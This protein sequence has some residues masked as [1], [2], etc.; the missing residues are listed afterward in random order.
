MTGDL[1]SALIFL[2][3]VGIASYL[4]TLVGFSYGVL[5]VSAATLLGVAPIKY[6]AAFVSFTSLFN[7]IIAL[8]D[9]WQKID[10]PL[11]ALMVAGLVPGVLCGV[12]L[13][14]FLSRYYVEILRLILGLTVL[15][16]AALSLMKYKPFERKTASWMPITVGFFGGLGGGLFSSSSPPLVYYIYKLRLPFQAIKNTLLFVF[17]VSTIARI[18]FI[19]VKGE[20]NSGL[21][22][23]VL[24]AL[25]IIGV[26]TLLGRRS[27][28]YLNQ[29]RLRQL[30]FIL[31]AV[32]GALLIFGVD[33][34]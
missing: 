27:S 29:E 5:V 21:L 1:E 12:I 7:I 28:T 32:M 9:N 8:K 26:V 11:G 31:M 22:L 16:S 13:L 25:P 33:I 20:V 24:L 2:L 30:S 15:A 17:F 34:S 23:N 18:T 14:D 4:Q 19:S 6:S 10:L 3:V